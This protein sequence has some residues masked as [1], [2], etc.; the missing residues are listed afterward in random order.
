MQ[1]F[2]LEQIARSANMANAITSETTRPKR[3]CIEVPSTLD[4]P[5]LNFTRFVWIHPGSQ[6]AKLLAYIQ[7]FS[8]ES[9]KGIRFAQVTRNARACQIQPRKV[10]L[11]VCISLF[12][13]PTPQ[14]DGLLQ[15][16]ADSLTANEHGS[17]S[18]C[19]IGVTLVCRLAIPCGCFLVISLDALTEFVDFT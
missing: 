2:T 11:R 18:R 5:S 1:V 15:I 19:A 12:R 7:C 9:I 10:E 14:F 13:G 8:G 17:Q 6:L 16:P 4:I 3:K